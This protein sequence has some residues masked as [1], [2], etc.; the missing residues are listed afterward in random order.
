MTHE[1]WLWLWFFIGAAM[2]WLKRAYYLVTGPN[3]IATSYP[4]FV[5]RCWIPLLVRFFVDSLFFWM[6]FTP[7]FGVQFLT[8][9]GWTRFAWVVSLVIGY[10]VFSAAFGFMVDTAADFAISKIPFVKDVLPQMPGPLPT[11]S[12]TDAQ[13]EEMKVVAGKS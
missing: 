9:M 5:K 7:N 13:A 12:P 2:Y 4:Q 3:P 1:I 10:A 11:K 8:F 6:L